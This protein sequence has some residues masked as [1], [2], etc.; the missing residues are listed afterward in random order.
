MQKQRN[1]ANVVVP[2]PR[3]PFPRKGKGMTRKVEASL[4]HLNEK[5]FPHTASA[6]GGRRGG[7]PSGSTSGSWP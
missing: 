6:G 2:I 5:L 4:R 7:C 3:R 1:Q